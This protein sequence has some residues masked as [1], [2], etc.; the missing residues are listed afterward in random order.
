MSKVIFTDN[1]FLKKAR[2]IEGKIYIT[3]GGVVVMYL[4][5]SNNNELVF[6]IFGSVILRHINN[7]DKI[8]LLNHDNQ[9]ISTIKLC[10][11]STNN[12]AN[13]ECVKLYKS[14]PKL[15]G[16]V[17]CINLID[18][19]KTWWIQSCKVV[20]NLPI[21]PAIL[22]QR[23]IIQ[24]N[25]TTIKTFKKAIEPSKNL[26]E[27]SEIDKYVKEVELIPE[28]LY[29]IVDG[30]YE[31]IYQYLGRND[32]LFLWFHFDIFSI[33]FKDLIKIPLDRK[34]N[35]VY[36]TPEILPVKNIKHMLNEHGYFML[37]DKQLIH[38]MMEFNKANAKNKGYK[39]N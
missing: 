37:S 18:K 11:I 30:K 28:N 8:T 10:E 9:L 13:I 29:Y 16:E 39:E 25:Q 3:Q 38:S 1:I 31:I 19:Y 2:L 5:R 36:K 15:Y 7:S 22:N 4:G 26:Q 23:I 14:L 32:N 33:S 6:Y 21:I 34:L 35:N 24:S 20:Q 27:T 17:N 12:P